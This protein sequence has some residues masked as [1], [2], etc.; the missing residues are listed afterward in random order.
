MRFG[1]PKSWVAVAC[2]VAG[3]T[4]TFGLDDL[5]YDRAP[6]PLVPAEAG[7]PSAGTASVEP[8]ASVQGVGGNDGSGGDYPAFWQSSQHLVASVEP[9]DG[10]PFYVHDAMS[11][12]VEVHQ[13]TPDDYEVT[14]TLLWAPGFSLRLHVPDAANTFIGYDAATGLAEYAKLTPGSDELEGETVAGT[15]GWTHLLAV[16]L[17]GSFYVVTYNADNGHYRLGSAS[18]GS[19]D[20]GETL[21]GQWQEGLS[22]IV[23]C[24]FPSSLD[25]S[26]ESGLLKYDSAT[27]YAELVRVL[28]QGTATEVVTDGNLG[29]GWTGLLAFRSGVQPRVLR[30][31]ADTGIVETGV[32][33]L[34][35][36]LSFTRLDD[37]VWREGISS[38]QALQIE[39]LPYAITHSASTRVADVVAL[40]PLETTPPAVVK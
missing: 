40:D 18:F 35:E 21:V 19:D 32:L 38:I 1:G 6:E 7:A 29:T 2:A 26:T 25:G 39:G 3:C 14:Q 23:A 17:D 12:T 37:A 22:H 31:A 16:P 8:D 10:A 15:P 4:Q 27:G 30:Y 33:E 28:D 36:T 9:A 24:S 34:G 11:G 13:P 20:A 5:S